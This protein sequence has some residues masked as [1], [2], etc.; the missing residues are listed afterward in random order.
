MTSAPPSSFTSSSFSASSGRGVLALTM[1]EPA[2]IGP[3]ITLAAWQQRD[4][5]ALPPFALLGCPHVL[6]ARATHLGVDIEIVE[7]AA[8]A[9]AAGVFSRALPVLPSTGAAPSMSPA[10]TPGHP[11]PQT[12][13]ATIGAIELA[14]DLV[15]RGEAAGLVT[16][17]IAKHVLYAA[18]FRHP[19]H[20]E[21]LAEL[22]HWHWGTKVLPVMMIASTELRV[23]PLTI[24]IPLA[25]V[26]GCL[27]RELIIDTVRITAAALMHDFGIA[28]PRIAIAGLNPHAGESGTIGD[29]EVRIL[30][31]AIAALRAEGLQVSGPHAADTLFHTAARARYDVAIGMYHD[32][33]LVPAKTLAFETGV[34][35]TLGLPFVRTSPDH[36]TAFDIA[37]TGKASPE[38]LICALQMAASMVHNRS[39]MHGEVEPPHHAA[40][41]T[42]FGGRP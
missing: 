15:R 1:G 20:T 6:R 39:R 7:I 31:P 33:V 9:Q 2:G 14:V 3:D 22:A 25:Q 10:S 17:P 26:A 18:G 12:A 42:G 13:A 8:L 37:G 32:Q 11:T 40:F 19:G 41:R 5:R 30:M 23:V 21:F 24:H 34:N 35:V 36:G 38:S 29:E 16:N 4:A 28:R 27:S